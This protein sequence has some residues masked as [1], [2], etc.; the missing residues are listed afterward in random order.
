MDGVIEPENTTFQ[1]R[2]GRL[3]IEFEDRKGRPDTPGGGRPAS[4]G[5]GRNNV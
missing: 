4:P 5:K 3:E 2:N 1:I